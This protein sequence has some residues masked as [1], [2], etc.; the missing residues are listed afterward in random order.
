MQAVHMHEDGGS[1]G[2]KKD[3]MGIVVCAGGTTDIWKENILEDLK[4]GHEVVGEFLADIKRE[5]GGGDEE[6]VTVAELRRLEQRNRTMEKF[7][8][9]FRRTARGSRYEGYPFI[10]E[11]K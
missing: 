9:E 5:F 2:G 4:G 7:V 1:S 10:E 8:Q 6:S 11:F 3:P